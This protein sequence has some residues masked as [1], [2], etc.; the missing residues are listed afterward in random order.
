MFK[1]SKKASVTLSLIIAGGFFAGLV[2]LGVLMPGIVNALL[3]FPGEITSRV[4]VTATDNIIV[5]VVAYVILA[6]CML[7]DIMI[8]M[9]L[10]RVRDGKVFSEKSVCLIRYISWCCFLIGLLFI[11]PGY[12]FTLA[13]VVAFAAMFLG[14]CVRVV[15]NVIE[16]ATEIKSEND[17]TV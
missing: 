15:K 7:A 3:R 5:L 4:S 2:V 6:I 14:L 1:I 13:F 17:L 9:L 16:E 12:Y 10:K 11:V 8:F